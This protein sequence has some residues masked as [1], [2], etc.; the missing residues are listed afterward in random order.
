MEYME[1]MEQY[2]KEHYCCPK[3]HSDKIDLLGRVTGYLSTTVEHFNNAKQDEF[4][5]RK[6]HTSKS[7]LTD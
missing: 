1:F 7:Q 5:N 6:K 2:S 4:H 3:C